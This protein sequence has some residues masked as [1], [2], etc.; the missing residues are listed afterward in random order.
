MAR[1][2]TDIAF[3]CR[4]GTLSGVLKYAN[5]DIG[6]HA[7][8]H[9][10]S[11]RRALDLY[12]IPGT[13]EEGVGIFQTTPDR[14]RIVTGA[15]QL[16]LMQLSPKGLFRWYAKCCD[17]PMFN[18]QRSAKVPFVGIYT[19]R[20]ADTGPLGPV[21]VEGFMETDSGKSRHV[22]LSRMMWRFSKRVMKARVSGRWR[23]TPFFDA[24]GAPVATPELA[25][26][27][28]ATP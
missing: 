1:S 21:I 5:P 16:G 23:Q 7:R 14:L 15:D 26:R 12:G 17:T 24:D 2:G 27:P 22:G 18:T 25:P 8:C 6:T 11:C 20:L 19:S 9:C 13:R 4:C 28:E 10:A 3:A